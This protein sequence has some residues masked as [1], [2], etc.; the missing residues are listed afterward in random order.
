MLSV[1]TF[2]HA[3]SQNRE[4]DTQKMLS[5]PSKRASPSPIRRLFH[6]WRN[7]QSGRKASLSAERIFQKRLCKDGSIRCLNEW[8][9]V[10]RL[11]SPTGTIGRDCGITD[12]ADGM[13]C[14]S[15]FPNL[16]PFVGKSSHAK[17]ANV[18]CSFYR[19]HQ[20]QELYFPNAL[21]TS[22][23]FSRYLL[24]SRTYLFAQ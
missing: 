18:S 9:L 2:A 10:S 12:F 16:S 11:Q 3:N 20:I 7:S 17:V 23:I 1:Q 13:L 22:N 15:Y 19:D 24:I 21:K 5:R 4:R 6:I 14:D 8:R